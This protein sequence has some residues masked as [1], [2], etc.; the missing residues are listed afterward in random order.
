MAPLTPQT[1]RCP[2]TRS[3]G[4][5]LPASAR[6]TSLCLRLRLRHPR[7]PRG[8]RSAT[9]LT[10]NPFSLGRAFLNQSIRSLPLGHGWSRHRLTRTRFARCASRPVPT[11]HSPS[12]E[13]SHGH[14]SV[15]Y[16]LCPLTQ[17]PSTAQPSLSGFL[18]TGD[19]NTHWQSLP[20]S[21]IYIG[22]YTTIP[23]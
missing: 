9:C 3:L 2:H 7:A 1:Q 11:H 4:C 5:L 14:R 18:S 13:P 21:I 8:E 23:F 10:G 19:V 22:G 12:S 17:P 15:L 6:R 16:V 20:E